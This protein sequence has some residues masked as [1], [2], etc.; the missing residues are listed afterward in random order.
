MKRNLTLLLLLVSTLACRPRLLPGSGDVSRD[1]TA[2]WNEI[3]QAHSGGLRLLNMAFTLRMTMFPGADSLLQ[4]EV[5]E[6]AVSRVGLDFQDLTA[7][8]SLQHPSGNTFWFW[9]GHKLHVRRHGSESPVPPGMDRSFTMRALLWLM[10]P[11]DAALRDDVEVSTLPPSGGRYRLQFAYRGGYQ[12]VFV[13]EVD[14]RTFLVQAI[15]HSAREFMVPWR[16]FR[17]ELGDY[18]DVGE[19]V[20][21]PHRVTQ[22]METPLG[23]F[24]WRTLDLSHVQVAVESAFPL[25]GRMEGHPAPHVAPPILSATTTETP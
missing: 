22:W 4:P 24:P 9:D 23:T 19:G 5:G 10:R 12:D 21:V 7:W 13:L 16:I 17:N 6:D 2:L 11:A 8:Q 25:P 18:R 14:P 1:P 20:M 3:R 15:E